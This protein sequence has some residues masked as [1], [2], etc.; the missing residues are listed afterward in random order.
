MHHASQPT[1]RLVRG[2]AQ[3]SHRLAHREHLHS[4]RVL[5]SLGSHE[6]GA[7]LPPGFRGS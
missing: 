4:L 6:R 7:L 1:Q 3:D 2:G 5:R